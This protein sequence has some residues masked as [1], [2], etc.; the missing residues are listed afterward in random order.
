VAI[1]IIIDALAA[2]YGGTA[3]AAAELARQLAISP[4][5]STVA[6]VARQGSIVDRS[7]VDDEAVKRIAPPAAS[8]AE[9]VRRIGWEA[10]DLP[11]V[12][13]REQFD[14]VISMSGM[15]PRAPRCPVISLLFNPVMYEQPTFA[16]ALRKWAVR[17]TAR[18]ASFLAAPSRAMAEMAATSIGR[19]CAVVPLGV[20]H[21]VF[22]PGAVAGDEILCVADFYAHK[23]HDLILDTWLELRPPRPRL[24]LIGNPRVDV[25]AHGSLLARIA[26][27]PDAE[28][29][30]LEHEVS[31]DRLA[32]AYHRARVFLIPSEHES[33][34]MPVAESMACGVPVVA[35]DLPSLRDTGGR[36]AIY[37]DGADPVAWA[38]AVQP[39]IDEDARYDRARELAICAARRFS[40]K[41]MAEALLAH[42]RAIDA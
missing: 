11:A 28:S 16:N 15:L 32:R 7:L 26:T 30:V 20:D 37:L 4:D 12:V 23:R 6:V 33:F 2:R 3:Y 36:G 24:R 38:A 22:F 18:E 35:R 34:C 31:R 8:R 27:L 14:A 17:R 19:D 40:W 21:S 10:F 5:V 1:R 41:A 39:L 29:I 25:K 13:A 42:L 9:L